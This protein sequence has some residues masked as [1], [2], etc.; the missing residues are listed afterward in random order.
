MANDRNSLNFF[1]NTKKTQH[2]QIRSL[3]PNF[4]GFETQTVQINGYPTHFL[5][6]LLHKRTKTRTRDYMKKNVW[7]II[8]A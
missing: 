8:K 6:G 7:K 1:Y 3:G 5:N 2:Q 4:S